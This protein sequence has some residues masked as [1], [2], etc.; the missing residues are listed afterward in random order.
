MTEPQ[1][2]AAAPA[3][4][5]HAVLV[6]PIKGSVTTED[7][8]VY[9]VSPDVVF[10]ASIEHAQQ[11][12]LAVG[13][14]YANEGHPAHMFTDEP[15]INDEAASRKN[16]AAHAHFAEHGSL[17]KGYGEPTKGGSNGKS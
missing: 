16:F 12:A 7:G 15:F 8:T 9:D 2:H 14:R 13:D 3:S 5:P 6:G 4:H 11:V 1:P 10:C 17:P